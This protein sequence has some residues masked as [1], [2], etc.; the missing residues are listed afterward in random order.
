MMNNHSLFYEIK[1]IIII[2]I[3][4]IIL[5]LIT[6]H[7]SIHKASPEEDLCL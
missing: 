7:W 5:I 4:I 2:I 1:I 3:I 6:K